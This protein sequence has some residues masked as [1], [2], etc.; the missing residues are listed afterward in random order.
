LLQLPDDF[1]AGRHDFD[2]Y[3]RC[4]AV[5]AEFGPVDPEAEIKGFR[6][7]FWHFIPAPIRARTRARGQR[8]KSRPCRPICRRGEIVLEMNAGAFRWF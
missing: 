8:R 4:L 5:R 7:S 6:P 3:I 1:L 2:T